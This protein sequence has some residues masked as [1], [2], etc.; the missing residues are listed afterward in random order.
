M[1]AHDQ[2]LLERLIQQ[3][4]GFD[5]FQAISLLEREG[6]AVAPVARDFS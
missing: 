6:V 4:Q 5:L 1:A 3:P 2:V